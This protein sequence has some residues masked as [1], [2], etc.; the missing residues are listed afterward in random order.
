LAVV[1][2]RVVLFRASVSLDQ[3]VKPGIR[4]KICDPFGFDDV[5]DF[6]SLKANNSILAEL[7]NIVAGGE[8]RD[9][10]E[11][12]GFHGHRTHQK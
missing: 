6:V 11:H 10:P 12:T 7:E 8:S 9:A 4:G 5:A 2:F 3:H 1:I